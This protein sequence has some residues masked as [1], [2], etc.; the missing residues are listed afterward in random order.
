MKNS[1]AIKNPQIFRIAGSLVSSGEHG[2]KYAFSGHLCQEVIFLI[3][4]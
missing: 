1:P 4:N 3:T 2:K